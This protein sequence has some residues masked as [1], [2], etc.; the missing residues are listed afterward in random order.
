MINKYILSF[1][2]A[3]LKLS[4]A[5]VSYS[6]AVID[7]FSYCKH[8]DNKNKNKKNSF[9]FRRFQWQSN[10]FHEKQ[11]KDRG[12]KNHMG[13]HQKSPKLIFPL[14]ILRAP[15]SKTIFSYY[16]FVKLVVN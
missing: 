15:A 8:F 11:T 2:L 13:C 16:L 1:G 7:I 5:K 12:Q 6:T 14:I 10:L 9:T 3:C 4:E